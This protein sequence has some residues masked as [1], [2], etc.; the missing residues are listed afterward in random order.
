MYNTDLEI[1]Q[2]FLPKVRHCKVKSFVIF[3]IHQIEFELPTSK[4]KSYNP[5]EKVQ[6]CELNYYNFINTFPPHIYC[7]FLSLNRRMF[8]F[9]YS[10]PRFVKKGIILQKK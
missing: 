7:K 4:I 1:S 2:Y 8:K 6:K 9:A 10:G 5:I 3:P